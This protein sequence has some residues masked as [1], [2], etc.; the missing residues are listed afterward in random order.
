MTGI[1][2]IALAA[3]GGGSAAASTDAR[4]PE[5]CTAGLYAGATVACCFHMH[6]YVDRANYICLSQSFE[7]PALRACRRILLRRHLYHSI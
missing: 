4:R 3:R 1:S 6:T 2:K 7:L 5:L